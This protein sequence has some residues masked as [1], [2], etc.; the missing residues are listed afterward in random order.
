MYLLKFST[1]QFVRGAI[2]QAANHTKG[3]F[4]RGQF[5]EGYCLG[6]IIFAVIFQ[7]KLSGSNYSGASMQ[8]EG[9]F[10]LGQLS[11]RGNCPGGAIILGSNFPG[12]LSGEQ[13]PPGVIVLGVIIRR[14]Q[15]SR[16][17]QSLSRNMFLIIRLLRFHSFYKLKTK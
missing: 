2:M 4:S 17:P 8:G 1:G 9:D 12:K 6:T 5:P 16:H 13:L 7:E 10:P 15:L 3:N 11:S 14:G